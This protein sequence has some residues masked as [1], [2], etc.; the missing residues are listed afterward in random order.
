MGISKAPDAAVARIRPERHL[1]AIDMVE[2]LPSS[3]GISNFFAGEVIQ[4][5]WTTPEF[6]V[7][8]YCTRILTIAAPKDA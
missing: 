6:T 3:R 2:A 5:S 1:T 7:G 4:V 8:M